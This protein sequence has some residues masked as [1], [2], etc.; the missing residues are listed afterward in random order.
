MRPSITEMAKHHHPGGSVTLIAIP[1][2]NRS[3]GWGAAKLGSPPLGLAAT[4]LRVSVG[5]WLACP[6]PSEQKPCGRGSGAGPVPAA[7]R[8][9][10]SPGTVCRQMPPHRA[11]AVG[12][13]RRRLVLRGRGWAFRELEAPGRQRC[14]SRC[15]GIRGKSAGAD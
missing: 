3:P 15:W 9:F 11:G 4:D 14:A 1:S 2:F 8:D 13:H 5:L 12:G 7:A 10:F 6:A